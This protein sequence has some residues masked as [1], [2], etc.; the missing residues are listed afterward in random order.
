M[1]NILEGR[2]EGGL[3]QEWTRQGVG[4]MDGMSMK[5]RE[6]VVVGFNGIVSV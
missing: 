6:S 3:T 1:L 5:V 2:A 4:I